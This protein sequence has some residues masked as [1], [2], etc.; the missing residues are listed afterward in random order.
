[1]FGSEGQVFTANTTVWAR[2]TEASTRFTVTFNGNGGSPSSQT[3][4][5]N[6]TGRIN[7]ADMPDNPTRSG[8]T[9]A[10]W[11]TAQTGGT[12]VEAGSST[13]TLFTANTT[14]WARWTEAATTFTITFNWNYSG[15][16]SNITATTR[17][18]GTL[19]SENVPG[20]RTSSVTVPTRSGFTFEGWVRTETSSTLIEFGSDGRVFT[21]NTT[22]FAR[23]V[24]SSSGG[25]GSFASMT[26]AQVVRNMGVGWNLGN[27]FEAYDQG[28]TSYSNPIRSTQWRSWYGGDYAQL[29]VTRLETGWLEAYPILGSESVVTRDL[30]RNVKRAGFDT[31]R[32]PVTW[33]KVISGSHTSSSFTI[34]S[35]WMT[36]IKQVVDWAIAE[37][38]YVILNTHHDEYITP[39]SSSSETSQSVTTLTRLW[40]LI[41]REFNNDYDHRLIFEVLNEPRVKGHA[42]EWEG[43]IRSHRRNLNQLN[44]AAVDAIRATG[45]NNRYRIL[46]IPT[47]AASSAPSW[48]SNEGGAFDSF[49]RP[50]D[51]GNSVNK[52]ILSIHA[53]EPGNYTGITAVSGSWSRS[54]ITGMMNRVQT[55][56]NR[57]GMPVVLG[58]WGAV[59]RHDS[60]TGSGESGRADY[61]RTYTQEA[62]SRGFV[63]VWWDTGLL[64]PVNRVEGRWGIMNRRTGRVHYT[65]IT[66]AIVAGQRAAR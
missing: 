17:A 22:V 6:G 47:Y 25:S 65:N 61:A 34:R 7:S 1:V 9:F 64:G 58:E 3:V 4:T 53:Y 49:V 60:P 63:P 24:A 45:G 48:A 35:D 56:A 38:M 59:A 50:T 20:H 21:E 62:V 52:M 28:S 14:V 5:T 8:H 39:F 46:M 13:G 33:H 12:R 40:T 44:Q 19:A 27:T 23:W 11:F 55:E 18:N 36:R 42:R 29:S 66:E 10:G 57:L 43:G 15:A 2:W 54:D 32:I 26:A 37:D 41:G 31:I 16:P 30:I 51:S